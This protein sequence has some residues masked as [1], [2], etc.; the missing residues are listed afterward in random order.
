M[1]A[2]QAAVDMMKRDGQAVFSPA[3]AFSTDLVMDP[4]HTQGA[5]MGRRCGRL[6]LLETKSAGRNPTTCLQQSW[7]ICVWSLSNSAHPT[8]ACG[9]CLPVA[10]MSVWKL[11]CTSV[12]PS[13]RISL[14]SCVA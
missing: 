6:R 3:I 8:A 14:T 4:R 9:L 11:A 13:L 12:A 7:D 10:T 2:K 1:H 5:G